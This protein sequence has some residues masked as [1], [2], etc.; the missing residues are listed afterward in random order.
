MISQ[1][2]WFKRY[3]IAPVIIG[4]VIVGIVAAAT[5]SGKNDGTSS[6]VAPVDSS[7]TSTVSQSSD[8]EPTPQPK[9]PAEYLSALN[10]A[11]S[12]AN[13]MNMSKQG[14]YDQL[15]SDYGGQFSAAAAKYAIKHV[16]ADWDANALAKAK[17]YQDDQN[18]SPAA[19]HDQL[20][21]QYGEEFTEAQA[22]Y[23]I[24]HLND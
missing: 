15:V 9:T 20:I 14:V 10:Q 22:D 17:E 7:I 16:K 21:S 4:L 11:D 24:Q 6:N 3:R 1:P 18:L 23:A 8:T 19:I 13:E 2:E 12:Y 5:S